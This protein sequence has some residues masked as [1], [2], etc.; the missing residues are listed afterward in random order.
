MFSRG[1]GASQINSKNP[2]SVLN[3]TM[4]R[5]IV[6]HKDKLVTFSVYV[7]YHKKIS[8]IYGRELQ[9]V[10]TLANALMR[11]KTQG[12]TMLRYFLNRSDTTRTVAQSFKDDKT[13][14]EVPGNFKFNR[15]QPLSE[16]R[17]SVS[18]S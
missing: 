6:L 14:A 15:Q 7:L 5:R 16:T 2:G 8:R 3:K 4:S 10:F 18:L 13:T 17:K 9:L 1:V 11:Y 12:E